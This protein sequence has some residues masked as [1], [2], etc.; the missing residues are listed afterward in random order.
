MSRTRKGT[1]SP[2]WEPWSNRNERQIPAPDYEEYDFFMISSQDILMGR[3]VAAPLTPELKQ[4]LD[5]LLIALNR[6]SMSCPISLTVSSGYRPPAINAV[7][8]GAAA[9]SN[10][11]ICLAAD[12]H[13][14]DGSLD[15]WCLDNPS[16]LEDCGLYQESPTT[17]VGWCHLQAI[18]PKSGHRVFIP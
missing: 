13:D 1:K 10:H 11:M 8:P 5:K 14:H 18:S 17:T 12:F 9:H 7:T 3:E 16:V 15:Q 6:F 2:G 4:N